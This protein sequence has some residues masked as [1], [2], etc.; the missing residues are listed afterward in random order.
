MSASIDL[1]GAAKGA[2]LGGLAAGVVG[3]A[4]FFVG[5]ALGATYAPKDPA[6]MGGL[7]RLFAAQPLL[8]CVMAAVVSIGVVAALTKLAPARAWTT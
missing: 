1:K 3:V 5:E 4:L 6:A 8:N 2:L 7:E